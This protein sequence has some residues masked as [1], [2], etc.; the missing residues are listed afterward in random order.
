MSC[1]LKFI[2]EEYIIYV[3]FQYYDTYWTKN[4]KW[5]MEQCGESMIYLYTNIAYFNTF[6]Y[7]W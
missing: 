6:S 3:F 2:K 4:N 5:L 1:S 7:R